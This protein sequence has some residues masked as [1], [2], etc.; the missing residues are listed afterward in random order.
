MSPLVASFG[1]D[2]G[3]PASRHGL[4]YGWFYRFPTALDL[5][6]RPAGDGLLILVIVL[7]YVAQYAAL[8]SA[9]LACIALAKQ[10]SRAL[11][12]ELAYLFHRSRLAALR[13]SSRSRARLM[14][15]S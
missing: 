6:V 3:D 5:W 4:F 2:Y 15:G 14:P 10:A 11:S 13:H 1:P 7:V 9:F 8:L 12:L